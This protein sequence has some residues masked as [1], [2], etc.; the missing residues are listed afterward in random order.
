MQPRS[1]R[2]VELLNDALS[3]ELA[4]INT[5]FLHARMLDS[6]G[7]TRLG[8]VFFDLSIGEMKDADSLIQRIL[9]FEGHP[10]VQK[11]LPLSVGETAEE[12]LTLGLAGELRVIDQFND[13]ARE[14]RELGDQGTAAVFDAMV[15]DEEGHA[16]WFEAQL[17]AVKAVGLTNYLAQQVD[18]GTGQA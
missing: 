13:S 9:M 3:A 4:V 7:L 1:P 17:E 2:V 10:N 12:I 16:D 6:W 15:L 5:Y 14:C 8:K 18:P 11:M